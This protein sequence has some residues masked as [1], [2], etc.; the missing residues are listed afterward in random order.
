MCDLPWMHLRNLRLLP[1][2]RPSYHMIFGPR[3]EHQR[4]VLIQEIRWH[5]SSGDDW[6]H[7]FIL[8]LSF[9]MV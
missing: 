5:L 4:A 8:N 3:V 1:C 9:G 6:S 7:W 2:M